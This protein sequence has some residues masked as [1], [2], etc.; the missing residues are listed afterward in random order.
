MNN[1]KVPLRMLQVCREVFDGD[2]AKMV[3]FAKC[4]KAHPRM[5]SGNPKDSLGPVFRHIIGTRSRTAFWKSVLYYDKQGLSLSI[6][7]VDISNVADILA[8]VTLLR[9]NRTIKLRY[10]NELLGLAVPHE[11]KEHD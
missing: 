4:Y 10:Q 8:L 1:R 2:W 7:S 9:Q 5:R 3:Q 11:I 6:D